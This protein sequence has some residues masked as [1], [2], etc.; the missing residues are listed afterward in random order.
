MSMKKRILCMVLVVFIMGMSFSGCAGQYALFNKAHPFLGNLG[1][2]WIGAI[3]HWIGWV[4]PVFEFCLLADIFIFNVIEFWT[5]NNLI[6]AGDSLEQI[7]ENG[8]RITAV[9]NDDGTLSLSLTQ[10]TGETSEY[11]LERQGNDF[12]MFDAEGLL[13]SSY[14]VSYEELAN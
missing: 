7:D 11:V 10:I 4:I 13:L 5:G 14:N 1:G 6:A 9:K 8:T 12:N 3:V 2:K